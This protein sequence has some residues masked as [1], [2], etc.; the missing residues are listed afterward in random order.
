MTD[1]NKQKTVLVCQ[2][3]DDGTLVVVNRIVAWQPPGGHIA[4]EQSEDMA[5]IGIGWRRVKGEW[6]AP[7][8]GEKDY[9]DE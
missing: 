1:T 5:H 3:D 9:A 2:Q 4:L 6:L 7:W 8:D